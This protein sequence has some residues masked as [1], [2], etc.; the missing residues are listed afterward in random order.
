VSWHTSFL[1]SVFLRD[2]YFVDG[3]LV[4]SVPVAS[5]RVCMS[6]TEVVSELTYAFS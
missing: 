1:S 6:N 2:V 4:T 3:I 5:V